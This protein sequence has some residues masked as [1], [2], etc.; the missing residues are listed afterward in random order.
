M[1]SLFVTILSMADRL[2]CRRSPSCDETKSEKVDRLPRV[3]GVAPI[4]PESELRCAGF[5]S[6]GPA[7]CD[8]RHHLPWPEPFFLMSALHSS[9]LPHPTPTLAFLMYRYL[10]LPSTVL[11]AGIL[12][13]LFHTWFP[14]PNMGETHRKYFVEQMF[15]WFSQPY[16]SSLMRDLDF[17]LR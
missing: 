9:P 2:C 16:F 8:I 7:V 14:K 17:I 15:P 12:S 10:T 13:T 11:G 6:S 4:K 1:D 3:T 5:Q